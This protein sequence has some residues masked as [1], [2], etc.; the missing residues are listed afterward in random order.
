MTLQTHEAVSLLV[1]VRRCLNRVASPSNYA[2]EQWFALALCV[3]CYSLDL[4]AAY[5]TWSN[6]ASLIDPL[7]PSVWMLELLLAVAATV[8]LGFAFSEGP[9]ERPA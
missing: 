2:K 6:S 1:R 3:I 9:N 4:R 8:L 7:H 5:S